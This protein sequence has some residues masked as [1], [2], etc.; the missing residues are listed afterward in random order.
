[1]LQQPLLRIRFELGVSLQNWEG[2]LGNEQGKEAQD[3]QCPAGCRKSRVV[4]AQCGEGIMESNGITAGWIYF[5]SSQ[6]ER[7]KDGAV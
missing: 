4:N 6:I 3:T 5:L 2:L 7:N 1:L